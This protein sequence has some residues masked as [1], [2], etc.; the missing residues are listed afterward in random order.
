MMDSGCSAAEPT[1]RRDVS[2]AA[3]VIA[4][5]V[6]RTPMIE[7]E[8]AGRAVV[9]KLELLQHTG[10][11]KPRG[12][13]HRVLSEPAVPGAGLI[14][15]SGGNHGLAV[16]YVAQRLGIPAEVFV[17]EVTPEVKRQGIAAMGAMVRV[18]GPLYQDALEASRARATETGALQVHAY[19]HPATVAGQGTM[20]RE[21]EEDLGVPA[22]VL[23]SVGGGGFAAGAAAWFE[24]A[25]ELVTVE[26]GGSRALSAA[27]DAGGPVDVDVTGLA[28]DSLGARR[29]GD[30]PW[31]V[32][33]RYPPRSVLVGDD[34]IRTAQRW[35]WDRLRLVVEPGGATAT[36]ALL[37]GRYEPPATASA[38][39]VVVC[40]AN[41]DPSQI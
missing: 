34:D 7:V 10:S 4:G 22:V 19:D 37:G 18:G 17:A 28:A 25:T 16:A 13:F 32:F 24:G 39:V 40:G 2:R 3:E 1:R 36:A 6:R 31:A 38:V 20:A 5:R 14:T 8:I 35:L 11:F 27:L 12:A 26:P 15:A 30:A 41:R 33:S 9:L 21:I 29:I 23:M